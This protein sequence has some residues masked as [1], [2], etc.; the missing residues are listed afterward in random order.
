MQVRVLFFG[1]LR[2]LAGKSSDSLELPEGASVRDVLTRYER[3]IPALKEHFSSIALAVNRA[4][5]SRRHR[6]ESR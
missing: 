1:V 5:C 4:I 2:D 6:T 3:E